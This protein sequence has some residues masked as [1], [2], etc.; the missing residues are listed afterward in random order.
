MLWAGD[1]NWVRRRRLEEQ[2]LSLSA[3]WLL[4]LWPA[5]SNSC[6][7]ASPTMMDWT[8]R[9]W[10][11]IHLSFLTLHLLDVLSQQDQKPQSFHE[12]WFKPKSTVMSSLTH[13]AWLKHQS[14]G[15]WQSAAGEEVV[16][17]TWHQPSW[18]ASY[19]LTPSSWVCLCIRVGIWNQ[20][21]MSEGRADSEGSTGCFRLP[22]VPRACMLC[23]RPEPGS[24]TVCGCPSLINSAAGPRLFQNYL[25]HMTPGHRCLQQISGEIWM[26]EAKQQPLCCEVRVH[27]VI[28]RPVHPSQRAP[29]LLL[30]PP[31]MESCV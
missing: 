1:P 21:K 28:H 24:S 22:R 19:Y 17:T 16:G 7:R 31:A 4:M 25:L 29:L 9:L 11:R 15:W 3:S 5:A 10:I 30:S 12:Q 13:G 8:L 14:L 6:S 20:L 27:T 26:V 2:D 18:A 23:Q